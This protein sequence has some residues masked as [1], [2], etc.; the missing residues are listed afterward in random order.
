MANERGSGEDK[1]PPSATHRRDRQNAGRGRRFAHKR[2]RLARRAG[3]GGRILLPKRA[4]EGRER[5]NRLSTAVA[6]QHPERVEVGTRRGRLPGPHLRGHVPHG[7]D[8]VP[9]LCQRGRV[10]RLCDAEIR[11]PEAAVVVDQHVRRLDVTVH[12]AGLV[13]VL[14]C[15]EELLGHPLYLRS[16][17]SLRGGAPR[18][19]PSRNELH[20]EVWP[21]LRD[22]G[23][24]DRDEVRVVQPGGD[25]RLPLE[26]LQVLLVLGQHVREHLEGHLPLEALVAGEPDGSHPARAQSA[27]E[28]VP[29]VP[30]LIGVRSGHRGPE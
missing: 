1:R 23:V 19:R 20:D 7:P 26:A 21:P 11:Q 3:P 10:P 25:A 17:E 9:G 15:G 29:T 16:R 27:F 4:E 8:H 14:E 24:E 6:Q 5:R 22:G 2:H 13:D 12:D 30:E 18:H 28:P